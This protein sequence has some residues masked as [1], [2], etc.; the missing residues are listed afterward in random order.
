MCVCVTSS[1]SQA[2]LQGADQRE[3]PLATEGSA[4]VIHVQ[5]PDETSTETTLLQPL[6][7]WTDSFGFRPALDLL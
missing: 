2:S 4:E 5:T 1:S 6:G 7:L 3:L